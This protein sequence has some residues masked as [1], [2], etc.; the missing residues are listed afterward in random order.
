MRA[1]AV[2]DALIARGIEANRLDSAGFGEMKPID[3]NTTPEGKANNRRV[4]FII[5]EQE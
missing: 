2:K 4:E 1:D 5:I 3:T